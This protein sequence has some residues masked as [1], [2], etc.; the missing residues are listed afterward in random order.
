[1]AYVTPPTP[2][3]HAIVLGNG[4]RGTEILHPC[5]PLDPIYHPAYRH[6]SLP[7]MT[8]TRP[9]PTT[10]TLP[11]TSKM[12]SALSPRIHL[13]EDNKVTVVMRWDIKAC[14]KPSY[15]TTITVLSN[16][17]RQGT[18]SLST[19]H[20]WLN[21]IVDQPFTDFFLQNIKQ[22][23]A[24]DDLKKTPIL[25]CS[26]KTGCYKRWKVDLITNKMPLLLKLNKQVFK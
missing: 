1:M 23:R 22:A 12:T 25:G 8:A 18:P 17:R 3:F 6:Y 7:S 10:T 20:K 13:T 26:S 21:I 15:W 11:S 24:F 4:M 5:L 2:N 19:M 14:K 16:S 9:L